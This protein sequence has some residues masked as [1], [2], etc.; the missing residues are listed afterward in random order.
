VLRLVRQGFNAPGRW[1]DVHLLVRLTE[2]ARFRVVPEAPPE[3]PP[4]TRHKLRVFQDSWA[5]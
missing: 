3:L 1:G 2:P 4:S 5:A